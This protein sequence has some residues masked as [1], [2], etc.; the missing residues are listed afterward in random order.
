[1]S[2]IPTATM[3]FA[4]I[5]LA[6]STVDGALRE[7]PETDNL[8]EEWSR[9]SEGCRRRRPRH[10]EACERRLSDCCQTRQK[11]CSPKCGGGDPHGSPALP[12]FPI[13]R[14]RAGTAGPGV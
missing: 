12:H 9:C 6:M 4:S 10:R 1:M 3:G 5:I 7:D 11:C 13:A 14:L 8:C 2:Q